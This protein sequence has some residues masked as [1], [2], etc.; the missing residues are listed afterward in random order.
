VTTDERQRHIARYRAEA[1]EAERMLRAGEPDEW[2]LLIWWTDAL[3]EVERLEA[4]EPAK[5]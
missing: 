2:N 3:R 1:A 5:G 4:I